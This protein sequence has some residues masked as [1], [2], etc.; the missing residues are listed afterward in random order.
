LIDFTKITSAPKQTP[1]ILSTFFRREWKVLN[2]H[3][4][5]SSISWDVIMSS[6]SAVAFMLYDNI[7]QAEAELKVPYELV[8]LATLAT[9]LV[10]IQ[11]SIGMYLA[12]REGK[13]ESFEQKQM[14]EKEEEKEK[15]KQ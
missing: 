8:L 13:R 3:P 4:A 10:G 5:Q 9:P 14:W 7:T 1:R 11:S 12:V 6:V 2:E 15:K